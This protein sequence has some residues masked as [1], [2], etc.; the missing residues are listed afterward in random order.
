[1]KNKHKQ[2]IEYR[3]NGEIY[4]KGVGTVRE[5]GKL[6]VEKLVKS[7]LKNKYITGE[8]MYEKE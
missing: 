1:M 5:I 8:L 2:E 3:P 4:V 6:N 7:L